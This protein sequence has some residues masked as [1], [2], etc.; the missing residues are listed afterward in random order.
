MQ[1][2]RH[3][4][5]SWWKRALKRSRNPIW[6]AVGFPQRWFGNRE[7]FLSLIPRNS[8]G[9]ELGVFR[10][11]FSRW[12]MRRVRPTRLHLVDVWWTAFGEFYPDWGEYTQSGLL[13]TEDAYKSV[14]SIVAQ[15]GY[16][17]RVILHA[18]DD[19]SYLEGLPD[20]CLDWAYVDSSHEFE[21]TCR[22]LD[23]LCSKVH[24]KGLIC[25]HDWCPDPGDR[26]YGVYRAVRE[27]CARG[28][29]SICYLDNHMQ[30][31]LRC[32]R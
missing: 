15:E 18:G 11:E 31:A 2:L 29:W 12:I 19:V 24:A 17:D 4:K 28:G 14:V 5:G 9:A 26:H 8:V 13:R 16:Q 6:A 30:W 23:V 21:H 3:P 20:G 7:G 10:G 32:R 25:G 1:T 27:F 22:E